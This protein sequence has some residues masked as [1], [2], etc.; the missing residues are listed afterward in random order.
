MVQ[1]KNNL[2]HNIVSL[3]N[4]YKNCHKISCFSYVD[5]KQ[6]YALSEINVFLCS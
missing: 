1:V 3:I 6:I 2:L 5:I 4:F